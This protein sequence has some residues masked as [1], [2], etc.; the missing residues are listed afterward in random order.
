MDVNCGQ[1]ANSGISGHELGAVVEPKRNEDCRSGV[2][3]SDL[4]T[5]SV[6]S[7]AR[8]DYGRARA[9][10]GPWAGG[11]GRY[12]EGDRR[13]AS[14][15]A[16]CYSGFLMR[17]VRAPDRIPISAALITPS[18]QTVRSI[19]R[20]V[21]GAPGCRYPL[22]AW[23]AD[24]VASSPLRNWTI[25]FV[26]HQLAD[27]AGG[28]QRTKPARPHPPRRS[29]ARTA[30]GARPEARHPQQHCSLYPL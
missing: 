1:G 10:A 9:R 11:E 30:G 4:I 17:D 24:D 18:L 26:Q 16:A 25:G 23:K 7:C 21:E 22:P 2:P 12:D 20:I 13:Q 27:A 19:P 5:P 6:G 3:I 15:L 8:S 28:R 29:A 14:E